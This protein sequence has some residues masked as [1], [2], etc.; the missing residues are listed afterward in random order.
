LKDKFWLYFI[1]LQPFLD[2]AT[3]FM[4]KKVEFPVTLG[5]VIRISVMI[6]AFFYVV[7]HF[8]VVK[9]KKML[10]FNLLAISYLILNLI[11]NFIWKDSFNFM[12]EAA[13]LAKTAYPIQ[14]FFVFY[15]LL[16]NKWLEKNKL[17]N[18]FTLNLFVIS[19]FIIIPTKLN[20]S[21]ESYGY[22]YEGSVG[23]FNAANE[24]GA[25]I[26]FLL[27]LIIWTVDKGKNNWL[28]LATI[29]LASYAAYLVGTKVSLGSIMMVL[30]ASSIFIFFKNK[31]KLD[32]T[33]V[34]VL[35]SLTFLILSF[36]QSPAVKNVQSVEIDITNKEE[37]YKI[38]EEIY[39]PEQIIQL[40]YNNVLRERSHP[41]LTRALSSRDIYVLQHYEYFKEAHPIRKVL[42]M[43]Y[44]SEY[45]SKPKTTEMDFFDFLFSFG[46][47]GAL[48]V[49]ISLSKKGLQLTKLIWGCVKER[50]INNFI[51]FLLL[52]FILLIS[53][54]FIAGHVLFAPSVS[55]YLAISFAFL[56][57]IIEVENEKKNSI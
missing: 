8:Y 39:T 29:L 26:A 13:F 48:I 11:I 23:W 54:S 42:G 32:K 9:E 43:G 4:L 45:E 25:I 40:E 15:I 1:I 37:N 46:I 28:G 12:E 7:K 56:Y 34:A 50:K 5:I 52:A 35:V 18:V 53:V 24:T 16:R 27:P 36:N 14:M 38:K 31:L 2:V 55:L 30:V 22:F 44:A 17:I 20:L 3:N 41:L 57:V 10:Y 6:F 51:Y 19:L 49:I 33:L 47:I 21:F